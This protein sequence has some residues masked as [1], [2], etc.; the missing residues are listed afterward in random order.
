MDDSELAGR[1]AAIEVILELLLSKDVTD[2][3][4]I[5]GTFERVWPANLSGRFPG[6]V[7]ERST[8][9]ANETMLRILA[10]ANLISKPRPANRQKPPEL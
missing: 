3:S 1:F 2:L 4:T 8:G 5:R 10:R 9:V 7:D 6:I